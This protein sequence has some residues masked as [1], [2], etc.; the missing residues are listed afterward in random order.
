MV[1]PESSGAPLVTIA[2][3]LKYWC[4][5]PMLPGIT[6]TPGIGGSSMVGAPASGSLTFITKGCTSRLG[7]SATCTPFGGLM[8]SVGVGMPSFVGSVMSSG[9]GRVTSLGIATGSVS[10]TWPLSVARAAVNS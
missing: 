3:A 7:G 10:G 1:N 5:K 4:R 9:L 6:T 8:S 2:R